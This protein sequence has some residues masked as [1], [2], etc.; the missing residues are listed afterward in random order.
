[1]DAI[2]GTF[3]VYSMTGAG[4]RLEVDVALRIEQDSSPIAV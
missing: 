4:T 2:G 1:V 3:K